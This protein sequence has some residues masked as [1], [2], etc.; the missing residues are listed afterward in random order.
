MCEKNKIK[1]NNILINNGERIWTVYLNLV[2]ELY[3]KNKKN[4]YVS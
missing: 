4:D 2:E 1:F 3:H